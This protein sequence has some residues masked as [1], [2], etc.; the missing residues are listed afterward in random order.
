MGRSG[1][2]ELGRP[3]RGRVKEQEEIWGDMEMLINLTGD[4]FVGLRTHQS[5]SNYIL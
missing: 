2:G 1:K 5:L 4:G 3:Q